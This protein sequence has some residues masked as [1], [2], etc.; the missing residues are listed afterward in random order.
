MKQDWNAGVE[1]CLEFM[2]KQLA[3]CDDKIKKDFIIFAGKEMAMLK[4][5]VQKNLDKA[6]IIYANYP[7]KAGKQNALSAIC[8]ALKL[9]PYD[10][11]LE[12]TKAYAECVGKWSAKDLQYVPYPGSWFNGGHYDD[13]RAT[14]VKGRPNSPPPVDDRNNAYERVRQQRLAQEREEYLKRQ[15]KPIGTL[16]EG[17]Q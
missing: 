8:K 1:A 12:A 11:L 4:Q 16:L 2:R 13:D 17:G 10:K 15:A 5:G 14:W 7:R 6:Q 3:E 9:V